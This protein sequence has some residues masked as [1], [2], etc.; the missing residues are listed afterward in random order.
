MMPEMDGYALCKAIKQDAQL[1]HIPIILLTAKASDEDKHAGLRTGADDYIVKPFKGMDLI[2]RAENLIEVRRALR[3]RFSQELTVGP[4]QVAV[5][6]DDAK[7]LLEVKGLIED[8]MHDI[9]VG[10]LAYEIGLG[11]KQLNRRLQNIVNMSGI[12]YITYMRLGRAAQL[13]EQKAGRVAEIADGAGY[14][15]ANYFSRI[16]KQ[17]FGVSPRDYRDGK[18]GA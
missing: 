10:T 3:K 4:E 11:E 7:F 15:D 9:T 17:A 16:F 5:Q 2:L 6:S 18:R 13:L 1:N 14:S 8:Q 12:G